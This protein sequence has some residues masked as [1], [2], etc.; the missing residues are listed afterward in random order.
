MTEN[1]T[2]PEKPSAECLREMTELK[3]DILN[4]IDAK[5]EANREILS[6][7]LLLKLTN[8]LL[9]REAKTNEAISDVQHDIKGVQAQIDVLFKFKDRVDGGVRGDGERIASLEASKN[10]NWKWIVIL[11]TLVAGAVGS[12][13]TAIISS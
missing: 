5:L 13:A 11:A 1:C 10:T 3:T 9:E 7:T 8:L 4:A 6:E 12:V 2:Q